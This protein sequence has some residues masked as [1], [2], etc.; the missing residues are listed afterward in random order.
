MYEPWCRMAEFSQPSKLVIILA[1]LLD[2]QKQGLDSDTEDMEAVADF[3]EA[4]ASSLRLSGFLAF[5]ALL[6]LVLWQYVIA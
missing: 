4:E 1:A 5:E 6:P 3:D 2:P